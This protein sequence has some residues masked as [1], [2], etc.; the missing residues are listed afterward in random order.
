MTALKERPET[1]DPSD[2][3]AHDRGTLIFDD[4]PLTILVRL[5][6][7]GWIRSAG[8]YATVHTPDRVHLW[9]ET[10][11]K[12]ARRLRSQRFLR[13]HRT[14]IANRDFVRELDRSDGLWELVLKGGSR[15][16]VARALRARVRA[17]L[18]GRA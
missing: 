16:P 8:N 1:R 2:A 17:W 15:L 7:I 10:M 4:G 12:A 18:E 3:P 11:T 13:I 6:D 14:A 9:R 5:A